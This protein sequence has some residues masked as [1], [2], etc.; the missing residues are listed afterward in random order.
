MCALG[1]QFKTVLELQSHQELRSE[2][3]I[4]FPH[5]LC[6][7]LWLCSRVDALILGTTET[8]YNFAFDAKY[9]LGNESASQSSLVLG[10]P[11]LK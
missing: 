2:R 10:S 3:G 6:A 1:H 5:P 7:P 4:A 11:I 8:N 9:K